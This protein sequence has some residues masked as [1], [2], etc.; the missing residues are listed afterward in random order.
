MFI[1]VTMK[2]IRIIGINLLIL[3]SVY[4]EKRI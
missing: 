3:P 1:F 2:E 4:G